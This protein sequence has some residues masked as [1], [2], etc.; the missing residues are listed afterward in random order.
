[1]TRGCSRSRPAGGHAKNGRG[2][3]YACT[4]AY[5]CCDPRVGC[6]TLAGGTGAQ[7]ED[8]MLTGRPLQF[9]LTLSD[10][11]RRALSAAAHSRTLPYR[12]V[13]RAQIVLRPAA[14]ESN[15]SIA[16]AFG[17]AISA[18]TIPCSAASSAIR[19]RIRSRPFL[20]APFA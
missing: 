11:E 10:P 7:P 15:T 19:A 3:P 14:G 20:A 17:L 6:I 18:A 1:M 16:H 9:E 13:R 5:S 2:H 12:H 4:P 8:P